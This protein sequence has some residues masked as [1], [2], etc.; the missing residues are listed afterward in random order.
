M[1]NPNGTGVGT[2]H[3][4]LLKCMGELILPAP[5]SNNKYWELRP[6]ADIYQ[7]GKPSNQKLHSECNFRRLWGGEGV[8]KGQ[9]RS[10]SSAL[11]SKKGVGREGSIESQQKFDFFCSD[12]MPQVIQK[13]RAVSAP[14]R[15][16]ATSRSPT[17]L[18]LRAQQCKTQNQ[19]RVNDIFVTPCCMQCPLEIIRLLEALEYVYF[20]NNQ[21]CSPSTFAAV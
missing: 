2:Y 4:M 21:L 11:L 9:S 20:C 10:F 6:R 12:I 15:T 3:W 14:P 1:L 18:G 5:F 13:V 8:G 17:L 19:D 16:Y 7:L